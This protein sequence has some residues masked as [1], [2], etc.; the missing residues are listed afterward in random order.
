MQQVLLNLKSTAGKM[1]TREN[2]AVCV[3]TASYLAMWCGTPS[4]SSRTRG[5]FDVRGQARTIRKNRQRNRGRQVF[6][7]SNSR[8]ARLENPPPPRNL[9]NKPMI[10]LKTNLAAKSSISLCKITNAVFFCNVH[11]RWSKL[12]LCPSPVPWAQVNA[13]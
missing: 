9:Q 11:S 6:R 10:K 7:Y 1:R 5:S 12:S 13:C 8:Q 4:N 3:S 2:P